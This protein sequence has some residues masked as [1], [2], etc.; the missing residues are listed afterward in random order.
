VLP[1]MGLDRRIIELIRGAA[2]TQEMLCLI[3]DEAGD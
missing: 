1:E 3:E 2:G